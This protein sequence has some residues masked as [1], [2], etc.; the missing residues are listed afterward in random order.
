M[1]DKELKTHVESALAYEPRL[2]AADISAT[3]ADGVVTLRGTVGFYAEKVVAE[4]VVL[5]V[6]GVRAVANDLT[7]HLSSAYERTDT[8]IAQAALTALKWTTFAPSHR[9]RL[10]VANGWVK[11]GGTLDW[12]FQKDAAYNAVRH[13]IG[14]IGITN[15]IIVKPPVRTTEV[16]DKI[17]AALKRTAEIDARRINVTADDGSVTLRGSVHSFA[18]RREIERAAWSA[19]GVTHVEDLIAVV[20]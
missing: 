5:H 9:I 12:Q 4:Q 16:R 19:P 17:E 7:V 18:E 13:L 1:T 11:L 14:V 3:A 10:T 20:P 8:E 6:Y 15:E 2:H